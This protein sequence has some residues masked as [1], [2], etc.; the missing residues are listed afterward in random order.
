MPKLCQILAIKKQHATTSGEK[1]TALYH[2]LQKDA[3]LNGISRTYKPINDDGERFPSESQQVQIRVDQCLKEIVAAMTPV[4]DIVAVLDNANCSAKADVVVEGKVVL[5]GVPAVTL[6]FL[7][8]QL[9]DLHTV[10]LKLPELPQTE[11]WTYDPNSDCYTTKPVETSKSKKITKPLVKYD[12]TKEHPAQVDLVT[13]DVL[14]GNWTTVKFS[15]ALP[16]DQ[17]KKLVERVEALLVAVKFARETAKRTLPMFRSPNRSS[18]S[19]W[20]TRQ[21]G[22]R[23]PD[24]RPK[25]PPINSN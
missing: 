8:K 21:R 7:E 17:K 5:S 15:G 18:I 1:L 6:L 22:R 13:E 14:T 16:R 9:V 12:A 10:F 24:R 23:T 2:Q 20:A 19:C 4:Y 25:R 3:L 11:S